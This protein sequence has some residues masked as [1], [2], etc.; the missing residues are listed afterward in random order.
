M[1][2]VNLSMKHKFTGIENRLVA[3]KGEGRREGWTGSLE[4]AGANSYIQDGKITRPLQ[5]STGNYSQYPVINH[6]EK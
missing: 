6:N 3:A 4:L 1:A 5:Y 2:Q